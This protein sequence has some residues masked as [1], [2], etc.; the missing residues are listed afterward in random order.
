MWNMKYHLLHYIILELILNQDIKYIPFDEF[1][2]KP[3]YNIQLGL[4]YQ[5]SKKLRKNN[6]LSN[7][8]ALKDESAHLD[9]PALYSYFAKKENPSNF[10]ENQLRAKQS[11]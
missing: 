2:I 7:K 3:R 1:T 4:H 11:G 10:P 8:I 9:F 5:H 6:F